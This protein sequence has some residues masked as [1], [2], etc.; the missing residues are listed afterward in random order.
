MKNNLN[1]GI[2][3]S[4]SRDTQEVV[5]GNKVYTGNVEFK[6]NVSF[7][8]GTSGGVGGG[9]GSTSSSLPTIL[10]GPDIK[11]YCMDMYNYVSKVNVN[12]LIKLI[13]THNLNCTVDTSTDF[14]YNHIFGLYDFANE[15]D[16]FKRILR[17][18]YYD[19]NG[20]FVVDIGG[21]TFNVESVNLIEALMEA[22][23][24]IEET[25][26]NIFTDVYNTSICYIVNNDQEN[27]RVSLEELASIFTPYV[28][29]QND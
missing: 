4:I 28:E 8:N 14:E 7:S 12:N 20:S 26:I 6:G 29:E 10:H 18:G 22:K 19:C 11:E 13:K 17:F 9:G 15:C 2:G 16:H 27:L 3:T 24:E 1:K 23:T 5:N 21:T 25:P